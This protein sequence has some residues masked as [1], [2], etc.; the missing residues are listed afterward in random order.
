[1]THCLQWR[2]SGGWSVSGG[3]RDE[4]KTVD[5]PKILTVT[6]FSRIVTQ[7]LVLQIPVFLV[8][9][10]IESAIEIETDFVEPPFSFRNHS[11]DLEVCTLIF[12]PFAQ[13]RV[14]L[15]PSWHI[16]YNA[17]RATGGVLVG[18]IQD[19][20][21]TIKSPRKRTV[22]MFSTI[23]TQPLELQILVF[24]IRL[25]LGI[26]IETNFVEHPFSFRDHSAIF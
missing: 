25:A 20:V 18:G 6:M 13:F 26:E 15:V 17:G 16:A 7:F 10:V 14:F 24:P 2:E 3:I 9:L 4:D 5:S 12:A 23:V 1:V 19:E 11:T 22:T 21:K 8:R